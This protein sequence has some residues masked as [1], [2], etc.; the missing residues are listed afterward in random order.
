MLCSL[1]NPAAG[2]LSSTVSRPRLAEDATKLVESG[3]AAML[4]PG[5]R[6]QL[7]Q[8][9]QLE[10]GWWRAGRTHHEGVVA[11]TSWQILVWWI[12][13]SRQ[14]W[15]QRDE[16]R[17]ATQFELKRG[18]QM[19]QKEEAPGERC[20]CSRQ[21]RGENGG[22]WGLARHAPVEGR[23]RGLAGAARG[24]QGRCSKRRRGARAR[25]RTGEV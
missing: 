14:R 5:D 25:R 16:G 9:L 2:P 23:G 19:T 21:I 11:A 20:G 7:Y 10:E 24:A 3:A 12:S 8:I 22:S 13:S 6:W 15:G 17:L 1:P 4:A 18:G